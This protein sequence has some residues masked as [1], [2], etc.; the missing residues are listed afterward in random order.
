MHFEKKSF[1]PGYYEK[2]EKI[3]LSPMTQAPD[4]HRKPKKQSDNT[5]TPQ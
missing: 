1:E 3:W 4:T 5:K 2:K